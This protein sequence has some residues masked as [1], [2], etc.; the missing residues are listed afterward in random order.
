MDTL[1]PAGNYVPIYYYHL[2]LHLNT[3]LHSRAQMIIQLIEC[4]FGY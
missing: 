3:L 1:G 4:N 2:P